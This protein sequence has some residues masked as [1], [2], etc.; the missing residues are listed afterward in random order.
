M[1]IYLSCSAME[2][3]EALAFKD[4]GNEL[5]RNEQKRFD[6]WAG[7]RGVLGQDPADAEAGKAALLELVGEEEAGW[8]SG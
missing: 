8:R 6:E 4:L 5:H 3:P 1:A 2:P 7:Q